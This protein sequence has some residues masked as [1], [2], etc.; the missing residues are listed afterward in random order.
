MTSKALTETV[1][2]PK[3]V[4]QVSPLA[5][6]ER[7]EQISLLQGMVRDLLIHGVDYPGT[8]QDSLWDPGA[9]QIIGAFN[10]FPGERRILKFEDTGEKISICVEVPII[11]RE[12]NLVV[13]I[14][15]GAASTLE[16]K[17]KYRFVDNPEE[18]ATIRNQL[19]PSSSTRKNRNIASPTLNTL[20]SLT[21][22]S[23]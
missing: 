23:K 21:L 11:S 10:C 16:S 20:S 18:G 19:K 3:P 15:I 5:I 14:G 9:S 1:E 17:Y 7:K 8:P 6:Q 12:T 4:P 2:Q 13:T 22:Y